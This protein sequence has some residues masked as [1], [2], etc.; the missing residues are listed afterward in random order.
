MELTIN[1]DLQLVQRVRDGHKEAFREIVET[2]NKRIFYLAYQ[3]TRSTHEAEDLS[4]EVFLKAYRSLAGFRGESSLYTWLHRITVTTFLDQKRK[5]SW[6]AERNAVELDDRI[7]PE[8]SGRGDGVASDPEAYARDRQ[9]G[10]L[11]ARALNCLSGRERMAF[12]M[13]HCQELSL[14]E[15]ASAMGISEGTAKSF[16][17]RAVQKMRKHLGELRAAAPGKEMVI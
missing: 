3:L 7:M 13:K 9:T 6:Q 17:Y 16:I 11:I 1:P 12:V 2:Y 15:V 4:Q 10:A 5:L 8:D 14:R